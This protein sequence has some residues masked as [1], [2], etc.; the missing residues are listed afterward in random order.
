LSV[1]H[2]SRNLPHCSVSTRSRAAHPA[3][4]HRK[5]RSRNRAVRRTTTGAG[6]HRYVSLASAWN[7]VAGRTV[8][9]GATKSRPAA[10]SRCQTPAAAGCRQ[11]RRTRAR[12]GRTPAGRQ[13][14]RRAAGWPATAARHAPTCAGPRGRSTAC[15]VSAGER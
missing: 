6:L 9:V 5:Q 3:P 4:A 1:A 11:R 15:C 2:S 10:P 13:T 8:P 14:A 12:P 7:A